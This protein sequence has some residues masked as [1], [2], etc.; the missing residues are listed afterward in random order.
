[1]TTTHLSTCPVCLAAVLI[2][3]RCPK[4]IREAASSYRRMALDTDSRADWG[5]YR[6]QADHLDWLA[7]QKTTAPTGA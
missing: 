7:D 6:R 5:V 4:G 3:D 2:A 1:M